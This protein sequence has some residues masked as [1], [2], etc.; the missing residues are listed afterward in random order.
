MVCASRAGAEVNWPVSSTYAATQISSR[1]RLT[2]TNKMSSSHDAAVETDY[3]SRLSLL[4]EMN[5][6]STYWTGTDQ[7]FD[8]N[9]ESLSSDIRSQLYNRRTLGT[10]VNGEVHEI[11]CQNINMARKS[12][13]ACHRRPL[14]SLKS[15]IN[16][17][18]KL[19]DHRHIVRLMGSYITSDHGGE[20]LHI[21]TFPVADCDLHRFLDCMETLGPTLH[22]HS[23]QSSSN[24]AQLL[25]AAV[26]QSSLDDVDALSLGTQLKKT[27]GCMAEAVRWIHSKKISHDDLKPANILLRRGRIFITDFGISRDRGDADRTWTTLYPGST[28][29]YSAPEKENQEKHN[30]FHADIYSLGCIYMHVISVMSNKK[31]RRECMETLSGPREGREKLIKQYLQVFTPTY[32][33]RAVNITSVFGLWAPFQDSWPFEGLVKLITDMLCNDRRL[34]PDITYV[35]DTLL[36]LGGNLA[37]FNGIC[38]L[39]KDLDQLGDEGNESSSSTI[40]PQ[41][42]ETDTQQKEQNNSAPFAPE[43]YVLSHPVG[44][45][46]KD[47][48][49]PSRRSRRKNKFQLWTCCDCAHSG[50]LWSAD[51][52][53]PSCGHSG[54]SYCMRFMARSS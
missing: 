16:A 10:G 1:H 35:N 25:A 39:P 29:G 24:D 30:P 28:R 44:D 51:P 46:I 11:Q 48:I 7:Q 23:T 41:E 52:A 43:G 47:T 27:M 54:C 5:A 19:E 18:Q 22:P 53:C 45:L 26:G 2:D 13:R 50:M 6:T 37:V 34:R 49:T 21:L 42:L 40:Q 31:K 12:V 17:I 9:Y 15:E 20:T 3:E 14:A 32:L 33:H 4:K 36:Q 38:C 8:V